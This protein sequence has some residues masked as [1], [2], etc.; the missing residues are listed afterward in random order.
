MIV[1]QTR[2]SR[3]LIL[4]LFQKPRCKKFVLPL[5]RDLSFVLV[6][7]VEKSIKASSYAS[8]GP[9]THIKLHNAASQ[10]YVDV[11]CS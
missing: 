1:L 5:S 3:G 9:P 6:E 4:K 8:L 2:S 11:S 10:E 7:L